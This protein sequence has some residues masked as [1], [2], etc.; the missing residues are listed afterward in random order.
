LEKAMNA[1][2][3]LAIPESE[4]ER[5]FRV[6]ATRL[7]GAYR[8][9]VSRWHPDRNRMPEA[10]SV[11]SHIVALY[12]IAKRRAADGSWHPLGLYNFIG[13]DGRSFQIKYLAKRG[14]ELGDMLIGKGIVTFII[15]KA[16]EDMVIHGL[17]QIGTMRYPNE[18][19]RRS[20]SPHLPCVTRSVET[21]K[22][23]VICMRRDPSEVLLSDLIQHLGGQVEP[24]HLAWIISSLLNLAC[25]LEVSNMTLNAMTPD[26]VFV[27]PQKHAVSLYGGW[28]YAQGAGKLIRHLPPKVFPLA[29]RRLREH[30]VASAE[31]DVECIRAIGRAC[32]GDPSGGSL[33]G[34]TDV[35]VPLSRFL[36]L[37]SGKSALVEYEHWPKVLEDSF[38]PRRFHEL[39]VTGD[40][41]YPQGEIDG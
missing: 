10:A 5:L 16:H 14:F 8:E 24:K 20:L 11:F 7:P 6:P 25:F 29:S 23:W 12:N 28:W 40:D 3:I 4:P 13:R 1:A 22:S 26:T 32:L 36:Q 34:R 38:G 35:P 27:S 9:L 19:F 2:A 37:P 41:V 33:R 31:L 21:A 17:K 39:K 18:Q 30:K 15:D